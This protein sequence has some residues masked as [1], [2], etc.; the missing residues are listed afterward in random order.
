MQQHSGT[1]TRKRFQAD[2]ARLA[3]SAKLFV[4]MGASWSL[5]VVST[6]FPEP[7]YLWFVTDFFNSLLGVFV[8]FIFVCKRKVFLQIKQRLGY[9]VAKTNV[10]VTDTT[11]LRTT[12][13]IYKSSSLGSVQ[14]LS[15]NPGRKISSVKK[16]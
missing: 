16:E 7:A 15:V 6:I 11:S 1:D 3:M 9:E 2:K 13:R 8:F 5:E 12:G 4:V 14:L 10:V